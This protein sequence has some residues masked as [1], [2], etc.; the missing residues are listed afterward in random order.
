MDDTYAGDI[1]VVAATKGG[2]T[3]L[4]AA[5]L[6]LHEVL[7]GV[8]LKVGDGWELTVTTKRLTRQKAAAL[9]MRPNSVRRIE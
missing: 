7:P 1:L 6:P 8:A 4:W 3:Q 2:Q 9:N 5:A